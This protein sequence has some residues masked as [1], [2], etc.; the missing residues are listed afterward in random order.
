[1][2]VVLL[3]RLSWALVIPLTLVGVACSDPEPA[4]ETVQP[5]AVKPEAPKPF[6]APLIPKMQGINEHMETLVRA[7]KDSDKDKASQAAMYIDLLAQAIHTTHDLQPG[8]GDQ[9]EPIAN[10]FKAASAAMRAALNQGAEA[11][12]KSLRRLHDQCL[13][14]HDQAPAAAG[15]GVCQIAD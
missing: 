8:Y 15:A 9:F 7:I 12:Q 13:R 3:S 10:E 6:M 2:H 1:V 4:A 5:A 11:T 14:C